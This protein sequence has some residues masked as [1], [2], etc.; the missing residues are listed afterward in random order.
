M[1]KFRPPKFTR[2]YKFVGHQE[3]LDFYVIFGNND[4]PE[5]LIGVDRD[6]HIHAFVL[7]VRKGK[8]RCTSS[9]PCIQGSYDRGAVLAWQVLNGGLTDA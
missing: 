4:A 1:N 5:R 3:N 2:P 7:S 9:C 6:E 8:P